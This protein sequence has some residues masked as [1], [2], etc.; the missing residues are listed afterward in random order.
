MVLQR[1]GCNQACNDIATIPVRFKAYSLMRYRAL[2]QNYMK[3]LKN[4]MMIWIMMHYAKCKDLQGTHDTH[5]TINPVDGL[6]GSSE[7]ETDGV[8]LV[9]SLT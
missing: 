4:S 2:N 7:R 6:N 1:L 9:S 8:H 3:S 5:D